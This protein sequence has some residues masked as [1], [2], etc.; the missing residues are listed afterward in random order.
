V[1]LPAVH[2]GLRDGP[3]RSVGIVTGRAFYGFACA[4]VAAEKASESGN[5]LVPDLGIAIRTQNR[6]EIGDDVSYANIIVTAPITG[7]TVKSTLAHCRHGILQSAP[8]G[9]RRHI[10]CVMVEKEQANP[11][12]RRIKWLSAATCTEAT[13]ICLPTRARRSLASAVHR[14][15]KSSAI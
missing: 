9:A 5:R 12:Q 14:W 1:R 7:Q 15:T 2:N 11:A 6:D 13:G 3:D 10:T 4:S 8:K